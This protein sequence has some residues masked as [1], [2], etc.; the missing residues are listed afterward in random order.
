MWGAA[1]LVAELLAL[2]KDSAPVL[3][4]YYYYYYYSLFGYFI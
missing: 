3:I 2:K 1:S 4:N